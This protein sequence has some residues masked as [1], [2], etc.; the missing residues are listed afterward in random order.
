MK[1]NNLNVISNLNSHNLK[2]DLI[3]SE[4]TLTYYIQKTIIELSQLLSKG[5]FIF[6]R[7]PSA[8]LFK[9]KLNK[10]YVP[11]SD[12]AHPLEHINIFCKKSFIQMLKDT[13]LEHIKFKSKFNFSVENF[14]RDLKNL[15]YFDSVL[16]KKVD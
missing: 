10:N 3:Y 6:L 4:E 7:F 9:S 14:L 2:Y 1:N 12:C 8:F 15:I 13:N 16:I 5:G 11:S